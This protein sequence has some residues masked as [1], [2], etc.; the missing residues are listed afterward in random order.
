[1]A[2]RKPQ[3]TF[4]DPDGFMFDAMIRLYNAW[5]TGAGAVRVPALTEKTVVRSLSDITKAV[6]E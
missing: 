1:M 3:M 4:T 2:A 6:A 5:R